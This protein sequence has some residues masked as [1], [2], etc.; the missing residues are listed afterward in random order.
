MYDYMLGGRENFRADREAA[1]TI[2]RM[3]PEVKML[4][5]DNRAFL[6]RAVRYLAEQGVGQF[7]DLGSG[8]PTQENVHE[9]AREV[10]PDARVVY[11]DCDPLVVSHAN[12]LLAK[13]AQVRV[14]QADFRQAESLLETPAVR[15]HLDFTRPVAVIL[16]QVLHF[17]ADDDDPE[18]IVAALRAALCPGSYLVIGHVTADYAP[19]NLGDRAAEVYRRA[20]SSLWPRS[21]DRILGLFDGFDLLEPGLTPEWRWRPESDGAP[22]R[23][24]EGTLVGVARKP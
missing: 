22:R 8:L 18:G 9:I 14:V 21:R 1:D 20:S 23:S 15:D 3:A 7:L 12:A 24:L 17:V 16:L 13:S 19:D 2:L 11:V 10:N 4:V 5:R 6:R